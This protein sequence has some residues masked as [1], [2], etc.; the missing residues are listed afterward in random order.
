[1]NNKGFTLIEL[2]TVISIIAI[3]AA[4]TLVTFPAA[5]NRAKDARIINAMQQLRTAAEA[6][7]G[8]YGSYQE[9]KKTGSADATIVSLMSEIDSQ[10]TGEPSKVF[11]TDSTHVHYCIEVALVSGRFWC[12]DSNM[13]SDYLSATTCA[14]DN[15]ACQ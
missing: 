4:I 14:A 10:K 6:S 5:T 8:A 11:T 1:M 13:H 2:L 7:K 3:L 15:I 9:I 12:V